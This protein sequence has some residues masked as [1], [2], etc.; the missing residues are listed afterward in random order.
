MPLVYFA[1]LFVAI[2][3]FIA[4]RIRDASGDDTDGVS[5]EDG[6]IEGDVADG[7]GSGGSETNPIFIA[8]PVPP[9]PGTDGVIVESQD[10]NENWSRRAVEWLYGQNLATPAQASAAIDAYMNG[11]DLSHGYSALVDKAIRQ[12]GLPPEPIQR[13]KTLPSGGVAKRQGNPP[14]RHTVKTTK[15]NTFAKLAKLYYN[16]D[17]YDHVNYL[18]VANLSVPKGTFAIGTQI[19]VP[20]YQNPKYYTA[21]SRARTASTIAAKNGTSAAAIYEL[22]D[23]IRRELAVGVKIGTRVRVR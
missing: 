13:G 7:G 5:S 21:N 16:S 23:S 12:F 6:D 8:K 18:E 17:H 22:N 15:E 10:S 11:A 19:N 9:T 2:L 4:W 3:V 14:T 1:A 20:K